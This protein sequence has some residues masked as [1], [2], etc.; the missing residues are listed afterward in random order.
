MHRSFHSPL[1]LLTR[2]AADFWSTKREN[3]LLESTIEK[4]S[5]EPKKTNQPQMNADNG[6]NELPESADE[7]SEWAGEVKSLGALGQG[8]TLSGVMSPALHKKF[9]I[10]PTAVG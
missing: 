1:Y 6:G 2:T 7:W 5:Q 8:H 4:G 3:Y 10:P 9:K